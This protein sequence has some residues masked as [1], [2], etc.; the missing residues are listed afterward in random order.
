MDFDKPLETLQSDLHFSV[1]LRARQRLFVRA[2]AVGWQG[3]AVVLLGPRSSGQT[4]L[5]EA[6]VRAGATYYSH[7]YAV[8]DAQGHVHPYATPLSLHEE[9]SVSP[10]DDSRKESGGRAGRQPLPVGL[11]VVS[12]YRSGAQWRPRRLT[13]AQGA[14]E[15][16]ANTVVA[17][18]QP[19]R[20]LATLEKVVSQATV[21]KGTRGEPQPVTRALLNQ[22]GGR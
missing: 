2:G 17:R 16:L 13:P 22:N 15:L 19:E 8:L 21:L 4:A 20:A 12:E 5:V 7:D 1:A 3:R 18:L 11:V 9:G 10:K 14:L 6:L